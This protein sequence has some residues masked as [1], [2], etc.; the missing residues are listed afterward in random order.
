MDPGDVC[1]I[2]IALAQAI[3]ECARD[4]SGKWGVQVKFSEEALDRLLSREPRDIENVRRSTE[5]I[6]QTMEYGLRLLS[7]KKGVREVVITGEGVDAPEKFI[8]KLVGETF[9]IE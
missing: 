8:N 9:K 3:Y 1:E 6:L 7:Q 5:T 4:S 2:F